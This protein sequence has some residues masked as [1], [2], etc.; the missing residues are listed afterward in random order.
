M[1]Q[2]DELP[3]R[4]SAAQYLD[5]GNSNFDLLGMEL[6]ASTHEAGHIVAA[7]A[8]F[9]EVGSVSIESTDRYIGYAQTAGPAECRRIW[10]A[11]GRVRPHHFAND[12]CT[13]VSMAGVV[14]EQLI[15]GED[16]GGHGSDLD[17]I[18]GFISGNPCPDRIARL[19]RATWRL[20]A[21]HRAQIELLADM[22][23]I[24]RTLDAEAIDIIYEIGA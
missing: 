17:D 23:R 14:A 8:L 6:S 22:L 11:S 21:H 13:I 16:C 18:A 20:L 9:I 19:V 5:I 12:A 2:R 7:K 1:P 15:L 4:N 3:D 24:H 10:R